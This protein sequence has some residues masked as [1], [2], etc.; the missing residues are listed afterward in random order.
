MKPKYLHR[1]DHRIIYHRDLC[2]EYLQA[3]PP[4]SQ[5]TVGFRISQDCRIMGSRDNHNQGDKHRPTFPQG[6]GEV[7]RSHGFNWITSALPGSLEL[8]ATVAGAVFSAAAR[9]YF[10]SKKEGE[11]RK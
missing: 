7:M 11:K 1:Y 6:G 4:I 5:P 3:W 10:P 8:A 9:H 2:L